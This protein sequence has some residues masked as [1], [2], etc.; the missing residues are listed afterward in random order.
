MDDAAH[1]ELTRSPASPYAVLNTHARGL[2]DEKKLHD[3]VPNNLSRRAL[4]LHSGDR[5]SQHNTA[6]SRS[7]VRHLMTNRTHAPQ[8]SRIEVN[9]PSLPPMSVVE[10]NVPPPPPPISMAEMNIPPPPPPISFA[11]INVPP[12]P[13]P[14][15]TFPPGGIYPSATPMAQLSA[16]SKKLDR[17]QDSLRD[18]RDKL[19]G[20]RFTVAAKRKELRGLHIESGAKD[21]HAFSL[22]RQYANEIGA[23]VPPNISRALADAASLRDRLGLLEVDYDEAEDSYN[24]LEW[25]YS[26]R[27]AI[28]VEQLLKKNLVP[29]DTLDRSGGAGKARSPQLAHP[30]TRSVKDYPAISDLTASRDEIGTRSMAELSV[31]IEEPSLA[32]SHDPN[33]RGSRPNP[34]P[35]S[36]SDFISVRTK[37]V[38]DFSPTHDHL[39]WMEKMNQIDEWLFDIVD[40]SPPQKLCLKA[41]H[42]FGFT[43]TETWW[44]HTKWLMIQEYLTHFHTGDSTE[45]RSSSVSSVIESRSMGQTLPGVPSAAIPDTVALLGTAES[46]NHQKVDNT[47]EIPRNLP[48]DTRREVADIE[49]AQTSRNREAAIPG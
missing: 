28:F 2:P 34:P 36:L 13:P 4:E 11:E 21:G 49:T 45:G 30:M 8:N 33:I 47:V 42:D 19:I 37:S 39:R 5:D 18:L 22:L 20:A 10:M 6:Q 23:D 24:R 29:S 25:T 35:K 31:F 1:D 38:E 17:E 41:I 7:R 12:P 43:D 9:V 14:M 46:S 3:D 40:K 48:A 32:T 26:R 44:E 15:N 16:E 27:E